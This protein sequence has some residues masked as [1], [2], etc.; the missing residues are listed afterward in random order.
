MKPPKITVLLHDDLDAAAGALV[1]TCVEGLARIG[2]SVTV[3]GRPLLED[4]A[5]RK[6]AELVLR[7]PRKSS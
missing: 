4:A 3:E 5:R 7:T 6:V 1:Q 2:V